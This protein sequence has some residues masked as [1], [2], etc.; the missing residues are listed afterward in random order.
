MMAASEASPFRL[1]PLDH[2]MPRSHIPMILFFPESITSDV[3]IMID[4]LREGLSRTLKTLPLLSGTV[5]VI[6]SKGA[7]G[8]TAPWATLDDIFLVKD[9]RVGGLDYRDLKERHFSLKDLDMKIILPMADLMKSEKTVMLVQINIIENGIIMALCL[10]HSFTDGNGVFTIA[11]IWAA[12]C[13][14][15]DGSRL[16]TQEMINRERLMRGWES[17]SLDDIAGYEIKHPEIISSRGILTYIHTI[18]SSCVTERLHVNI[19]NSYR[20]NGGRCTPPR[21][22]RNFLLRKK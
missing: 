13:R 11:K 17:A 4:A 14:K 1:T 20:R 21:R 9:L 5:R 18:V 12:Y 10:H 19:D 6:D 7:L 2:A 22:R 16:V 3:S 15:D 8:V